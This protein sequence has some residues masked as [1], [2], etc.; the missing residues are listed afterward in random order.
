MVPAAT[1]TFSPAAGTYASA[2]TVT[3]SD[4]TAGATIYYTIDGT[5]PSTSSTIYSGPIA[6]GST[7]T[8]S[9]IAVA[10]GSSTSAVG[11]AGYTIT[12]T[13][14]VINFPT[15]FTS[16]GLNLVGAKIVSGA[17]QLTDGGAGEG[18]AAWVTSKVNV[19]NFATDFNFQQTA[20]TADGFTFAIQNAPAGVWAIGGNG[21]TL[22]YGGIASSVGV[23]FDLY[24]NAGEGSDS[25]GIYTAGAMPT[26]PSVDMTG[27]GV[28]L[29]SGDVMHAHLSYDGATLTVTIT[30]TVTSAN[31][32]TSAAVNIPTIVGANT[33]YVGFTGGTGGLTAVQNVLNWT[34]VVGAGAP[35]AATPT[36]SPAAGSYTS[37][38]TVAISDTTAGAAIYYTTNGTTPT[39][40]STLYSGPI[41][42][43]ATE[44]VKAIAVATGFSA[45]AVGNA[46]YTITLPAAATPT[47]SPVAGSYSSA[48]TVTI[49]DATAGAAIYYTTNGT[50][51]TTASAVYSGPVSVGSTET[52]NAIAVASGFSN[53]ATGS[54]AYTITLPAAA[55]PTFS[56]V[57]GSYSSAQTVTISD[58]T[59]GATIYYTTNGTTPTT[60]S[61]VYSVPV[62]VGSTETLNAIAV[63]SGFS[64]SATGTA[65]YT[66]TLPAAATPTFSPVAGSYS[67]AQTVT[68]SDATAGATIYY[69]TNGTAPTTAS[70]VYSGPV[71]V[72]STETLNA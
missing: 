19:Q 62:S 55:T 25:T 36:F 52:L 24:S 26:L 63:A 45:S 54:A 28:N 48:Q 17:L 10:T 34:Y 7:E 13:T 6:V 20:A 71:S 47:F 59:A 14:P 41:S 11:T 18:R 27:S 35:T 66:I 40:A 58:A 43:G 61:T 57:A 39:T 72:G 46:A 33:A 44:T 31:F 68:I 5:T 29:H 8:L 9:A 2:Q 67:S 1:P 51:P 12:A 4:A 3:I 23:K 50:A 70:A 21:A 53:S 32:T 30:D 56:P 60:A 69:T 22:G 37:V 38:Q 15:S 65:A 64:N 42:V 49:S 16:T